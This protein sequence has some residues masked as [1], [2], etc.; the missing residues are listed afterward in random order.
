MIDLRE[1][2]LAAFF[3]LLGGIDGVT[4]T[5]RNPRD[6]LEPASLDRLVQLDGGH[7]LL[8]D[9]HGQDE[10]ALEVDVEI[11]A[12]AAS[13]AE[14]A[15]AFN[16]LWGRLVKTVFDNRDLG[17]LAQEVR[18]IGMEEPEFE[19]SEDVGPFVVAVAS[20]EIRFATAYGDP[21]TFP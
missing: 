2:N 17:G 6:S 16:L 12:G 10:Y 1:R 20:F 14:L 21:F 3:A 9:I 15:P 13:E 18:H 7:R 11:Y 8:E 4:S 5:A 19:R